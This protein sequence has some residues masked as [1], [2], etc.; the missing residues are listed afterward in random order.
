VINIFATTA[1]ATTAAA[2]TVMLVPGTILG[3]PADS[4]APSV[5]EL[6]AIDAPLL[7]Q[8]VGEYEGS[9]QIADGVLREA[10]VEDGVVV[11]TGTTSLRPGL[12]ADEVLS[13]GF[14]AGYG[15][16]VTGN[17]Y[18][19]LSGQA[20]AGVT[21]VRVVSASGVVTSASLVDGIWGAVWRAG[22]DAAEYGSAVLEFDTAAGTG[23]VSTDD[24]D[25]IATAQKT[26]DRA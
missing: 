21:A 25:A 23:T 13:F 2:A 14:V 11:S 26:E 12:A 1:A 5:G 18:A 6:A 24:V 4:S 22:D 16:P 10:F 7:S 20:G 15:D 17:D 8:Q 9:W 19:Q 3:M